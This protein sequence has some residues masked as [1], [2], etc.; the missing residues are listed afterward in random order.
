VEQAA[1]VFDPGVLTVGFARRVATYK[2]LFLLNRLPDR[3]LRLLENETMPVQIVIAGKAHPQDQEA[4]ATLNAIFQSKASPVVGRKVAFLEDYDLHMAPRLVAGVDLWLNLPR[5]PFEAS[6]TSGMKVALNGGLNVSVLDGWW[7]EAYDGT[8]GWAIATPD[9]D[10]Q[11]QDEHDAGALFDLLEHEIVPLFYERDA[12]GLP[13]RWIAR[14]KAAMQ[15]LVP[16]FTATRM[17]RDYVATL[18]RV[19]DL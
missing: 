13:S 19:A 4:K 1:R 18:Y 2:R 16:R 3:S 9:T 11:A 10:P 15:T 8:N 14:M 6:G 12:S 7:A 5:P 17:L